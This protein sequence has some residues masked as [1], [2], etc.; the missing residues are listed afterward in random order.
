MS[1]IGKY[2]KKT[3]LVT[4]RSSTARR[5]Q[6]KDGQLMSSDIHIYRWFSCFLKITKE[7]EDRGEV[8][9]FNGKKYPVKVDRSHSWFK[10]ID[11]N[12]LPKQIK[13]LQ[14]Q[15]KGISYQIKKLFDDYF[16]KEYRNL[17]QEPQSFIVK[18]KD[19]VNSNLYDLVAI[20]KHYNFKE[21]QYDFR[22]LYKKFDNQPLRVR[23][24]SNTRHQAEIVIE[25]ARDLILKRLFH[26]IR[27]ELSREEEEKRTNKKLTGLDVCSE[28][29]SI[30]FGLPKIEL[31]TIKTV[32]RNK[33]TNKDNYDG[34]LRSTYRDI[35]WSK[36]LI[37]NLCKGYFPVYDKII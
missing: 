2:E 15:N 25:N 19:K 16:W 24:R 21:I 37:L 20:P 28:V 3:V 7:L 34:L 29:R 30:C 26:T 33:K 18:E 22:N 10:K 27:I 35:K 36:Y 5:R 11:L 32:E 6:G 4:G 8:F 13:I 12:S 17:F 31:K 14:Y 23:S 1:Y 9:T